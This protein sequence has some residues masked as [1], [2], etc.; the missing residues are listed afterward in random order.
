[1]KQN[2]LG[3]YGVLKGSYMESRLKYYDFESTKKAYGDP[4]STILKCVRDDENEE[5]ILVELLTTNEKIRIK[6]EGYELTSKPKFDIGDNVKLIKYPDKKATVRKIY[7]HDK[8]KRI[9]Y[10]LNVEND[11]R[12]S[13]SRYYEDD[14]K[15]ERV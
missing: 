8:D 14:N 5:Y 13:A 9:Y 4:T 7:W 3:T 15:F 1:M 10:L 6:R 12:K 2:Y 11:K